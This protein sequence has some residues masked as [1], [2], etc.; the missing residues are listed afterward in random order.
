MPHPSKKFRP[1]LLPVPHPLGHHQLSAKSTKW[2]TPSSVNE[3]LIL[4]YEHQQIENLINDY[5]YILDSVM[6][7]P[8]N[9]KIWESLFTKDCEATYPFGTHYGRDGMAQWCLNAETR[10]A[11]MMHMSANSVIRF[12]DGDGNQARGELLRSAHGRS[13]LYSVCGLDEKDLAQ[14]FHEGGWYYWSFRKEDD[15]Q[16]KI[17]YL[18][19]DVNWT[20]GDSLGLNEGD[21]H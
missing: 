20:M 3:K 6:V 13:N 4:V 11:R 18:F 16:W 5:M 12:P 14:T 7:D 2:L 8:T 9:A 19:L 21:H 1:A 17:C 15:G 10:F